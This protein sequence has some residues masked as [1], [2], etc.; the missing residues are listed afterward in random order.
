MTSEAKRLTT[1]AGIKLRQDTLQRMTVLDTPPEKGFDNLTRLAA[2]IFH[3]PV[4]LLA[5][6]DENRV[7]VKSCYGVALQEIPA[8]TAFCTYIVETGEGL[9][10]L[11][12][13]KDERLKSL[14]FAEKEQGFL[15]YAGA[16]IYT[17]EGQP[18]GALCILDHAPRSV[19]SPDDHLLLKTLAALATDQMELRCLRYREQERL[20][21]EAGKTAEFGDASSLTP[22]LHTREE[23]LRRLHLEAEL[24]YAIE[25]QHLVLHYQPEVDLHSKEVVGFEALIRWEHPE[26]GLIPPTEFIPFAEESGLILPLGEWGLKEACRQIN[27][28]RK[29]SS[30]KV[31]L[32][33]SVNLSAKQFSAPDLPKQISSA[34]KEA[35]LTGHDLRLEV[36]ESCLM[37]NSEAALVMLEELRELGVGLQMDDFGTGYSSLNYLHRFPFDTLKID[38]SFVQDLCE[39]SHS[40]QIVRS[41]ID[42]ARSLKLNVVAE[43]IETMPQ[44]TCLQRLGCRFGQGYLFAKPLRASAITSLLQTPHT[45]DRQF[46]FSPRA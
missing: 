40:W 42:L 10:V 16:A 12:G 27:E 38:R 25:H 39:S 41:I 34:L 5:L 45:T 2:E 15:F 29:L 44:L 7:W 31:N 17:A 13:S 19:W 9:V 33:V 6:L 14:G 36:T 43:G 4:A 28:W 37:P 1:N 20:K 18:I 3:A 11:D 22:S 46:F 35:G 24:R 32:R 30:D 23:T 21:R 26:H 8:E